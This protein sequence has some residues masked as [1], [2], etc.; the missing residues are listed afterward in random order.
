MSLFCKHEWRYGVT[1]EIEK[2]GTFEDIRFQI[3]YCSKCGKIRR[4][5]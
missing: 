1:V 4:I 5:K 2:N 3:H